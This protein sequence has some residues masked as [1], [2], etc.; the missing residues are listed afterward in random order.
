MP[1]GF[2]NVALR[3]VLVCA[4]WVGPAIAQGLPQ[5]SPN[6]KACA[7]LPIA[8]LEAHF[9]TK[10]QNVRGMDQSTRA[11]CSATFPDPFRTALVE[12]HPPS[13]ADAAMTAAQRLEF[14]KGAVKGLETKDF[15][16]VGC[17]RS[18]VDMGKPVH[19][20]MCFLAKQQYFALSVHSVDPAQVSFEAVR[21]LL[22]KAAARFK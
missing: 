10:A 4:L 15:G 7:Y 13:A 22:D 2:L 1:R 3:V 19:A 14:V 20:T 12:T 11:T 8:E 9:G 21:S 16:S 5:A 17:T 6:A 18:V